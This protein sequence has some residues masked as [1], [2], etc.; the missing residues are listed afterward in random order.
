MQSVVFL[1]FFSVLFLSLIVVHYAHA[2][3]M[4]MYMIMRH[5]KQSKAIQHHQLKQFTF[6]PFQRK[7]EL[8]QV[9]F[10]PTSLFL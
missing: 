3:F 7:S 6:S 2:L 9:G 4:Y 10:E 5:D 8:P 1:S